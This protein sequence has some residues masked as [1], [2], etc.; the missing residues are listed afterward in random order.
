MGN[1]RLEGKNYRVVGNYQ[2]KAKKE[3]PCGSETTDDGDDVPTIVAM[4]PL[5]K[6]MLSR[7]S[8]FYNLLWSCGVTTNSM[9]K[10]I[11]TTR[12]RCAHH[13]GDTIAIETS[14]I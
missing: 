3:W 9:G 10:N 2:F 7:G 14:A 8:L 11:V 1:H 5:H 4:P 12:A 6:Q 13:H